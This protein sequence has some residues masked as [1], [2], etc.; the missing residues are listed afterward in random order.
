M[1]SPI[2]EDEQITFADFIVDYVYAINA[3]I[4]KV[5][6]KDTHF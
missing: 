1:P 2:L 6:I 4:S 3:I 5:V